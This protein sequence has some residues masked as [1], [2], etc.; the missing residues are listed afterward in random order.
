MILISHRGNINGRKPGQENSPSY[1][2]KALLAGYNVEVDVWYDKTFWLG[3]DTPLY[4]V[5]IDYLKNPKLWCH[6]KNIEALSLM[7]NDNVHCFFH[8]QDNCTLT[9]LGIIWTFPNNLL[10]SNSVCVLPELGYKGNIN[11][12]YGI[13]SDNI[14]KYKTL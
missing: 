10:Y 8:K 9:S 12:C 11:T 7:L 3:H 2:E 13:C 6:A 14:E 4:E 5:D 1:I